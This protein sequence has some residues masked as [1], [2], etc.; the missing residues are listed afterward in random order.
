MFLKH[1]PATMLLMTLWVLSNSS[2][3]AD[4]PPQVQETKTITGTISILQK[5]TKQFVLRTNEGKDVILSMDDLTSVKLENEKLNWFELKEG[6]MASVTYL[7]PPKTSQLLV[8]TIIASKPDPNLITEKPKG[9][10]S[11]DNLEPITVKGRIDYV[12]SDLS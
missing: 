12:K 7:N 11:P 8:S 1:L 5:A 3:R 4:D 6:M 2:A 9:S 10:G